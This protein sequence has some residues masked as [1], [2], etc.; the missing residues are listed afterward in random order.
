MNAWLEQHP[1]RPG[2]YPCGGP[3]AKMHKIWKHCAP[4]LFTFGPDIYVPYTAD[5]MD[6]YAAPDNPLFVP[7]VRKDPGAVS[8]LLYAFGH[9]NAIGVS[10]FGVEDINADPATLKKPPFFVKIQIFLR[11]S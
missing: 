1:W 5:V 6:E 2:T 11:C 7:E 9:N 4:S 8:Y 10:P 3:I